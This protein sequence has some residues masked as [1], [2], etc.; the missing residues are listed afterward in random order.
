VVLCDR[1][2]GYVELGGA[3]YDWNT[4]V[5]EMA[6]QVSGFDECMSAVLT[7]VAV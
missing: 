4:N 6:A 7:S 1:P 2:D 5:E 3:D